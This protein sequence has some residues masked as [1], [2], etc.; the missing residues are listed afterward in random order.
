MFRSW[1]VAAVAAL[2]W[3]PPMAAS[4]FGQQQPDNLPSIA[5]IV[6][7]VSPSV[8]NIV[9]ESRPKNAAMTPLEL[10][11]GM[12]RGNNVIPRR[13]EGSGF[14]IDPKGLILT[15][16]HVVEDATTLTINMANGR[17][18]KAH[19]KAADSMHDVAVLELEQPVIPALTAD[20][21][22]KMGD[23]DKERPGDWVLAIG[24]PFSLQKTVTKGIVSGVGRHLTIQGKQ[25]LNLLQTDALIN[26]GNSG[27]PLLN[28]SGEVI[29]INVAINPN[30][31]GIGFAIPIDTARRIANDL[32]AHGRYRPTWLGVNITALTEDQ[33][34]DFGVGNIAGVL[35][36]RTLPGGPAA[37]AGLQPG[38]LVTQVNAQ[39]IESPVDLKLKI[40][41]MQ[42]GERASLTV[43]R[44]GKESVLSVI[45]ETAPDDAAQ[46]DT[47]DDSG[48]A[49]EQREARTGGLAGLG[50]RGR[51]VTPADRERL[52]LPADAR[53][54]VITDVDDN[55]RGASLGV[56]VDDVIFWADGKDVD[57]PAA[58]ESAL[59]AK[60][61]AVYL[62]VW[63]H[64][65]LLFLQAAL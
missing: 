34:K 61:D 58:L 47:D 8:V 18:Y 32:I 29:G 53:G 64:G 10:F 23:S 41:A 2:L 62:K 24:S 3:V 1:I 48:G 16:A 31:Q 21:V 20:E 7:K 28:L 42:A 6:E 45:V 22:A 49:D 14:V 52:E 65:S 37:K 9:S 55:S 51:A 40:E 12:H 4:S 27:G 59:R 50:L 38:D 13:G 44:G 30:A 54:V 26:P 19:V 57:A 17:K 39:H 33:A 36:Q 25:Y 11:F 43:V 35:V 15:A 5:D 46:R 56:A 60:S 63:R